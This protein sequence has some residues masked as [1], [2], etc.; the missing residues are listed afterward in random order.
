MVGVLDERPDSTGRRATRETTRPWVRVIA[1]VLPA[2][3]ALIL[4]AWRI[5]VPSLWRDES[6]SGVMARMPLSY[7]RRLIADVDAVHVTYYLLLRPFAAI[8]QNEL[9]LRLPSLLAFATTAFGVAV[10]GRRLAGP[11]AGCCG[12]LVYALLPL[13]D[14]YAQEA[15]SY[16]IV[17]AAAVLSTWLLLRTLEGAQTRWH[18]AYAASVALLGWLHLYSLLLLAAHLAGVLAARPARPLP[19]LFSVAAGGVLI[20]PLV[21]VAAGQRDE[22]LF[23]LKSPGVAD[24]AG[25]PA[26]ITGGTAAAVLLLVL[27]AAGAWW[28]RR[29]LLVTAWPVLPVLASFLISQ[30]YPVY[31]PRYVL[32]AIPGLALLAG[33]GVQ[34]VTG[35]IRPATARVSVAAGA[36]VLLGALAAPAQAAIRLPD[37]RPDDLRTLAAVLTQQERPGDRVLFVPR[38]YR[39]FVSVYGQPYRRL[40]DLTNAPGVYEPRTAAEFTAAAAGVHRIWLI[41]PRLSERYM[42]D[43]RLQV[44]RRGFVAGATRTFGSVRLT[45]YTPRGAAR[46]HANARVKVSGT[47]GTGQATPADAGTVSG[48]QRAGLDSTQVRGRAVRRATGWSRRG[49]SARGAGRGC[50]RAVRRRG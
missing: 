27:A 42:S 50:A 16:A 34:A 22:Q 28:S 10:I 30:E 36:I 23:W 7:V 6:F 47:S 44:L 19:W 11:L 40:V 32:Y 24:L 5:T 8:A 12:G 13:A 45:P 33:I 25:L 39:L 2:L 41:S 9:M 17:S 29:A 46:A 18:F 21:I 26:E 35:A 43:P 31:H 20:T 1:V 15:R 37:S 4:G 49:S 48:V 38:R 3:V 14:R